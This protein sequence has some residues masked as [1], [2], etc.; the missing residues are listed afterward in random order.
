MYICMFVYVCVCIPFACYNNNTF[1]HICMKPQCLSGR[2]RLICLGRQVFELQ[3]CQ[4][5]FIPALFSFCTE[6]YPPVT[7]RRTGFL[8]EH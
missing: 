4:R 2:Y 3:L 7:S 8:L 6:N 5:H 1:V